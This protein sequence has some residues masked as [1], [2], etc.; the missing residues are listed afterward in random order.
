MELTSLF[1]IPFGIAELGR[2]F[3]EEELRFVTSLQTKKNAGNST[4]VNTYV[5]NQPEMFNLHNFV[6]SN[7]ND[8]LN[9]YN[10]LPDSITPYITQSWVNYNKI[11]QTH[12]R[13]A[14]P[15][16]YISGVLYMNADINVD[17]IT[18]INPLNPHIRY[19]SGKWN[20]FNSGEWDVPVCTGRLVLF[21]ST[22]EHLV[23]PKTDTNL[24]ISLSFNTFLKGT[25][26]HPNDL[27]ELIL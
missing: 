10:P 2:Q 13:H 15:N 21:P 16:S 27:T 4:S 6:L 5:L 24:R 8:Y 3:T 14:H 22:L 12:H 19:S 23:K 25:L 11:N 17:N 18:F 9:S 1:S 20:L 26:G 7:V